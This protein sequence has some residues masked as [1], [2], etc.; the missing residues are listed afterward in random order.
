VTREDLVRLD[1][2][3]LSPCLFG[4]M[5][6]A[7]EPAAWPNWRGPDHD[8]VARGANPPIAWRE[9]QD[10]RWKA[11]VPG[12][13][14]SSPIV[15]G[16]RVYL[17]SREGTTVVFAATEEWQQLAQNQ[18]DDGFD[19]TAAIAGKELFLRGKKHLYCIAE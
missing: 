5:L 15:L 16:D 14:S 10:I 4:A 11:A 7:Q 12:L 2:C 18:L 17:T 9:Q 3:C 6:A 1:L 8:A 19:A 13:G